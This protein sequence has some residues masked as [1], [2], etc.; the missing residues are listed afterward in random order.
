MVL[1]LALA[2]DADVTLALGGLLGGAFF[3]P[4]FRGDRLAFGFLGGD[5]LEA[6]RVCGDMQEPGTK[7]MFALFSE[8]MLPLEAHLVE[9]SSC[10]GVRYMTL[11]A[12]VRTPP[13][14]EVEGCGVVFGK[15]VEFA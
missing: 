13:T 5:D 8:S 10:M 11:S 15:S 4:A 2:A 12:D 7:H 3:V 14:A 1:A 9:T 6:N